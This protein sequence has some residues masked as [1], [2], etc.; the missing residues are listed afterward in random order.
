MDYNVLLGLDR[1]KYKI[2]QIK[3]NSG[4]IEIEVKSIKEKVRCPICNKFTSSVHDKL[5]PIK[6]KYLD[7]CGQKTFL[8]INKRRFHCY[9]C[10][11][12][13]HRKYGIK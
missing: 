10:K 2:I 8:I 12:K 9:N 5:K 4:V 13:L 1:K 3:E 11:K 6:S 7:C